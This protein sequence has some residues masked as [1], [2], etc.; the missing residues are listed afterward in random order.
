[1]DKIDEKK[2]FLYRI[3]P[4]TRVKE[5]FE[6]E[7]LVFL[8][9]EAWKDPFENYLSKIVFEDSNGLK[10]NI[11][12]LNKVYGQCYSLGTETSLMWDAYSPNS[13]GV[14]IKIEKDKLIDYL[15]T[16]TN[17]KGDSF[18]CEKVIYK[19][20]GDFVSYMND[21]V[22]LIRLFRNQNS[23]LIKY[24]F[25][26]RYEYRDE[27][28]FRIMYDTNKDSESYGKLLRIKIPVLDIVDSVR[29]DPKMPEKDCSKLVDYFKN[30]GMDGRK[31]R[32]SLLYKYEVKRKIE[33]N[34]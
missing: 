18:Y 11:N 15:R 32:R 17:Y 7:E 20:Y 6:N 30:I 31:V 24:L 26:K 1:M 4:V 22:N 10:Y 33:I 23:G 13:D 14:R 28:E 5:L 19:R 16:S 25:E 3:M 34:K 9:P 27:R 2:V 29:F 8:K 12:Y 21:N